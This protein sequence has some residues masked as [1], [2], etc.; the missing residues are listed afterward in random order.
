VAT[1]ALWQQLLQLV[2]TV[3]QITFEG[4]GEGDYVGG[5]PPSSWH[6]DR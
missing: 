6:P 2:E 1:S 4:V 5:R 3:V